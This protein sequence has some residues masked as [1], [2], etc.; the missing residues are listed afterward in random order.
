MLNITGWLESDLSRISTAKI[1]SLKDPQ[2][3][4]KVI[5]R[6]LYAY[7]FLYSHQVLSSRDSIM[8]SRISHAIDSLETDVSDGSLRKQPFCIV[9]YGFPGTGKSSFAIQV[10]RALMID[11]YGSFNSSDMVTLNETDEYQSEFRTSHKVVLFDDIGASAYSC[12]DTKNPWR[13]IVDFVNNVRKTALNPNVEMKGKV[14]IEPDLVIITSNLDF[15]KNAGIQMYIPCSEAIFRRFSC[16]VEVKDHHSVVPLELYQT[17]DPIPKEVL[18]HNLHFRPRKLSVPEART[19]GLGKQQLL[20]SHCSSQTLSRED[21]IAELIP[22]FRSHEVDQE[23]FVNQFN[24]YFDDYPSP[25][26]DEDNSEECIVDEDADVLIPA[27][28]PNLKAESKSAPSDISLPV[29]YTEDLVVMIFKRMV[30]CLCTRKTKR[31]TLIPPHLQSNWSSVSAHGPMGIY[32]IFLVHACLLTGKLPQEI[33]D[34]DL[35]NDNLPICYRQIPDEKKEL[36]IDVADQLYGDVLESDNDTLCR[37]DSESSLLSLDS[38]S[39]S[40]PT[41]SSLKRMPPV[42]LTEQQQLSTLLKLIKPDRFITQ[43]ANVQLSGFGEIDLV[44]VGPNTIMVFECKSIAGHGAKAREQ[45]IRYS[46]VMKVLYP[47]KRVVGITFDPTG[48]R[49]ACDL[50]SKL[51]CDFQGFL[52]GIGY[53]EPIPVRITP[54]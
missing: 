52:V 6:R 10:A 29:A 51:Y 42:I 54:F 4:V 20:T 18:G 37:S 2:F 30:N 40:L 11:K 31:R 3:S 47:K 14:Y 12:A 41:A 36:G 50:G 19:N 23:K 8:L 15:A 32:A 16:I 48:I 17:G 7:R 13:K 5:L 25:L 43:H 28:S 53:L 39:S 26:P 34:S 1:G 46:E 27:I 9:L 22:H 45:A 44:L 33:H 35:W 21:Y 38:I 49:V 24:A